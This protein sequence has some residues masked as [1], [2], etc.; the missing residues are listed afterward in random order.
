MN[1]LMVGTGKGSWQMR[2]EQ[3]GAALGARVTSAPSREDLHWSDVVVLIKRAALQWCRHVHAAGKPLVWDALDFWS[4]PAQNGLHD[5]AAITLLHQQI[6]AIRPTLVIGATDAMARACDG[7]YLPHQ[8][9]PGL[10]PTPARPFVE[11]EIG[12]AHV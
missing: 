3:L 7:V 6:A 4:Q 12:R 1:V 9:W 10:A 8:G 5:G 2:G 11:V